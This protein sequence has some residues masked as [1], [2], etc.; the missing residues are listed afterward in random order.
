MDENYY[1]GGYLYDP[2][3]PYGMMS[4]FNSNETQEE[5]ETRSRINLICVAICYIGFPVA[6]AM[7]YGL[8]KF[9]PWV[10]IHLFS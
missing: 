1:F 10:V 9:V 2:Y 7:G 4:C 3:S 5:R 6:V 8:Y